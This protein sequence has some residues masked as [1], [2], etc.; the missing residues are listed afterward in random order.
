MDEGSLVLHFVV[1]GAALLQT[2]TGIGFGAVA[3]PIILLVMDSGAA[4][5]VSILLN[6]LI[7][8]VL[9]PSLLNNIDK[10]FLRRVLIGSAFGL[11]IGIWVFTIVSVAT[12]K[13]LAGLAVFLMALSASGILQNRTREKS[14][15]RD[16]FTG[17]LSGAM[18]TVLAMPGPPAAARMT[19]LALSK[20]AIRATTLA[21]FIFSYGAAYVFQAY[22]VGV[23]KD[24]TMVAVVLVPATLIGILLGR[25][26]TSRISERAFRPLIVAVLV[27]TSLGLLF[28]VAS[29]W[30]QGNEL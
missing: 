10:T 6:L 18:S 9:V 3:G 15:S 12:L 14:E 26:A 21:L 1:L 2:A 27:L 16:Y 17:V 24:V 8:V 13:L 19:A 7:A 23:S 30:L 28:N 20:D 25:I 29:E 5:Q 22:F 11:P 4:I